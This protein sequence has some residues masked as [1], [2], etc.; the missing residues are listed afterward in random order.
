M[1]DCLLD[2]GI[3]ISGGYEVLYD[4]YVEILQ[5][6]I[7]FAKDILNLPATIVVSMFLRKLKRVL[8][9]TSFE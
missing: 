2:S 8:E 5:L 7:K 6:I 4:E 1:I 9:V 3:I